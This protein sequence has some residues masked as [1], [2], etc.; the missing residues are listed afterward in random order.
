MFLSKDT[1]SRISNIINY[2]RNSMYGIRKTKLPIKMGKSFSKFKSNRRGYYSLIIFSKNVL[3]EDWP[4][5]GEVP[6]LGLLL[7]ILF[8]NAS[9][10]LL[11][12]FSGFAPAVFPFE[13]SATRSFLSGEAPVYME[14]YFKIA[15]QSLTSTLSLTC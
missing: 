5:R 2:I 12:P 6:E 10:I 7:P 15:C 9:N 3:D 1:V 14:A 4:A 8:F 13:A 11:P